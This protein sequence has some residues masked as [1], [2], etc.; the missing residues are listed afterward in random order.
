MC[1]EDWSHISLEPVHPLFFFFFLSLLDQ[2]KG[3][4][5]CQAGVDFAEIIL[6]NTQICKLFIIHYSGNAHPLAPLLHKST[7]GNADA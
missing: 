7:F 3:W 1:E 5:V 2:I 4:G 6:I